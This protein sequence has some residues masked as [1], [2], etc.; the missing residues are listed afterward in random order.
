MRDALIILL[1][2]AGSLVAIKRPWIG[3]IVWTWLSIMSPHRYA[4]GAAYDAPLAAIAA[5]STLT[6]LLFTRERAWPF[7]GS[8]V[9]ALVTFMGW[10]TLSWLMGL[11]PSGDYEQWNKVMKIDLMIL[12]ALALLH[13]KQHVFALTWVAI[14][15]MALLGIKGGVFTVLNGGGFR[16]YGPPGS[17]IEDNN[18]F[19]LAIVM[20]IP[21]VRFLQLQLQGHWARHAM[22]VV[23]LLCAASA[24]GSYSRGGF[25][26]IA[27]MTLVLWWRGKSRLAGAVV[28]A[29]V[30]LGLIMFMPVE[31]ADRMSSIT[32]YDE[33]SS[34]MGRISA[35]WTAW[36]IAFDYPFGVG[37]DAARPEL[38]AMY[39]PYPGVSRAAH[40][41]YFQVLGNHGFVGL[42]IFLW[43]WIATWRSAA[44]LRRYAVGIPEAKWCVELGAMCQVSLVGYMAGGAFLSLA[45][46]DLPYNIMVLV[47]V[48]RIWVQTRGWER[49]PVY[50]R[51]WRTLPGLA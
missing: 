12:V 50:A 11:D 43:I 45:Y 37:F 30:A 48:T 23:M 16:V 32:S 24:L 40:S 8:A 19:A 38:F 27:A 15:S 51:G 1:V 25:I 7:K 17:F 47:M 18:A 33:D 5:A 20:T 28:L 36:G 10:M 22:T 14:G 6:G 46:F 34:A 42:A 26:A 41:N 3:V 35:W 29:V 49:E 2:V 44:W 31:W 21:M 9:V 4:W 13:T 39:S